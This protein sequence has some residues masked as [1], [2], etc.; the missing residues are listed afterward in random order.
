MPIVK[1]VEVPQ[2]KFIEKIAEIPKI[3]ST[4]DTQ[5][6]ESLGTTSVNRVT[7]AETVDR[8]ELGPPLPAESALPMSTPVVD[9]PPV[10]VEGAQPAPVDVLVAPAPIG[11]YAAPASGVQFVVPTGKNW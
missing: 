11:I 9:V 6:S 8:A 1:V 3:L 4:Q 7:F 2:V 5:T 10:V